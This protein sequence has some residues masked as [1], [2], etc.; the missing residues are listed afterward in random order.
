MTYI[1]WICW[2]AEMLAVFFWL[3]SEMKLKYLLP[4]PFSFISAVYL[5]IV[6]ALHFSDQP[7]VALMMVIIPAIPLLVLLLLVTLHSV[8][9]GKWI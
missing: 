7:A 8:L 9:G 6:L 3:A 4:N 5:F 1:F 2:A